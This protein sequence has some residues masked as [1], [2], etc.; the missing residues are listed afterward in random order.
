MHYHVYF[1]KKDSLVPES[2]YDCIDV[3]KAID[4]VIELAELAGMKEGT[5]FDMQHDAIPAIGRTSTLI[6]GDSKIVMHECLAPD[7]KIESVEE[8]KILN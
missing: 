4:K 3:N 7:S 5:E 6:I 8:K 1:G 2:T